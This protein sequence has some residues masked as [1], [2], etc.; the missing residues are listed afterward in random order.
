MT[1][2][3]L[4]PA[5]ALFLFL[6]IGLVGIGFY[7]RA[8]FSPH[9]EVSL[10]A[11]DFENDSLGNPP[12]QITVAK[13]G[14]GAAV[15]VNEQGSKVLQ[16]SGSSVA[17]DLPSVKLPEYQRGF[18][19]PTLITFDLKFDAGA[20]F[21]VSDRAGNSPIIFAT[22]KPDG[23]VYAEADA[24]GTPGGIKGSLKSG[25]WYV[26]Y[27]N[28]DPG[29]RG[30]FISFIGQAG[31]KVEFLRRVKE[32]SYDFALGLNVASQNG[33]VLL[34]NIK[35]ITGFGVDSKNKKPRPAENSAYEPELIITTLTLSPESPDLTVRRGTLFETIKLPAPPTASGGKILVPANEIFAALGAEVQWSAPTGK[36]A[37]K[38]DDGEIQLA[39]GSQVALINGQS[40]TLSQPVVAAHDRVL[41]PLELFAAIPDLKTEWIEKENQ[42][43]ISNDGQKRPHRIAKSDKDSEIKFK[44]IIEGATP[45]AEPRA[46]LSLTYTFNNPA[47]K[48]VGLGW[49]TLTYSE[50]ADWSPVNS[51]VEL[52]K[53]MIAENRSE[54]WI[55]FQSTVTPET[56]N[57]TFFSAKF[58]GIINSYNNGEILRQNVSGAGDIWL[59]FFNYITRNDV[60]GKP[61]QYGIHYKAK[62]KPQLDLALVRERTALVPELRDAG[63]SRDKSKLVA[64]RFK[65]VLDIAHIRD[66]EAMKGSDGYYYIVGTPFM[67]GSIPY[68]R[69][70]NDGIELFRS[71]SRSGPF[72]SMGYVWK[73]ENAKWANTKYF[74]ADQARNIWAPEIHELNGKWYLVY[75]PT[76]FPKNGLEGYSVFQIGIAV[77]DNPLGPYVD[78]SDTPIVSSPDPHLF[79]DDDGL[80]YLTYGNGHIARLKPTM[81]GLAEAPHFIYPHNAHSACNEGSTLF[82]VNGKYYFGGAFS[83]HYFDK[84]GKYIEQSYDCELAV[85]DHIYGP[86]GDRFVGL[87][88]AGNNSFFKDSDGK[89]YATIWQPGKITSIIQVEQDADGKWRPATNYEVIS[90]EIKY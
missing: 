65:V 66:P 61:T 63:T 14:A 39:A 46:P 79:Q 44:T 22:V 81:D 76:A 48:G 30:Y 60:P 25:Q 19:N 89:W 11:I 17:L 67:H 34:D 21:S 43:V 70:I 12:A 71:Q 4:F 40:K 26:V 84:N 16:I 8:E 86:Y 37:A 27:I 58:N 35:G 83:N 7:A 78:T 73:F 29:F 74:T 55:R 56:Y 6:T 2:P 75:F 24:L 45:P 3:Q 50:G 32:T 62:G 59:R 1:S 80:I 88:N 20:E 38:W 41:V 54:A 77:A 64:D 23:A 10:Y 33:K 52:E 51:F 68:A 85:A 13:G 82:K 47:A 53:R 9:G 72:Q 36:F 42:I 15:V 69:G 57:N 90:P 5:R 18:Q 49:T 87:K 28:F 31:D